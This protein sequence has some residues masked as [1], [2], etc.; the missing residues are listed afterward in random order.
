MQEILKW[1]NNC[2]E[3][4]KILYKQFDAIYKQR[5]SYRLTVKC[6][7][8]STHKTLLT[9]RKLFA[10]SVVMKTKQKP[11]TYKQRTYVDIRSLV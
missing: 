9:D 4:H 10:A 11:S 8:H 6:A 1:K 3:I 5:I 2:S 7:R